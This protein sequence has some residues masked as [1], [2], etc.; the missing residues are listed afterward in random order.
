MDVVQAAR[1][2]IR[3]VFSNGVPVYMSFSA[4]KDSLCMSHLVYDQ[5]MQGR[6]DASLLTVVFI[7]EEALYPSMEAMTLRW[8][9]RFLSVG[10]QFRWYCLPLKQ[11][12]VLR[13][14][15][16]S[17][18]WITWEPG[19]E[20]CWVRTPPPWA[21]R[22]CP[23]LEYVGQMTYQDFLTKITRDGIQMTGV[24]ASESVQRLQY[25]ARMETKEHGLSKR[26]I[27]APIYDWKD[28]DI[29]LY[30]KEHD[31]DF[32]EAYMDL[33]RVGTPKPRLRLSNYF[34]SESIA[35]LRQEPNAYLT[36]LY[37]DSEMFHRS[38]RKRRQME[39]E[40]Q[41]DY[42]AILT[43]MLLKHP[44]KYFTNPGTYRVAMQY[45]RFFIKSANMMTPKSMRTMHD[46]LVAGDP[47][48]R[49][50]RALFTTVYT[51]Y[52]NYNR[53]DIAR[54]KEADEA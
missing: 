28:N 22:S 14:L 31:L 2:R 29:W 36:L 17:E 39:G 24:R 34:A 50:L 16:N 35:G 25:I 49:S 26:N 18:S 9:K 5:I 23:Y 33:Y 6:I 52:A 11:I 20:D 15:Q 21:I 40:V 54:R 51:D 1:L 30:I 19:K 8:R 10:A 27:I 45:R 46:A 53:A 13:Q 37:W 32:P 47:K 12:S 42:K 41:K 38:T 43:E 3:N 48:L 7:D 4:G 44:E